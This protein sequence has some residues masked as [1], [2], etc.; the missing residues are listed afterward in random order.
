MPGRTRTCGVSSVTRLQRVAFA[1]WLHRHMGCPAG[2]EPAESS[3]TDWP[4][5]HFGI[6]QQILKMVTLLGFEPRLSE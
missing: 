2:L 4:L 1:A 6:G 3:V 5:D